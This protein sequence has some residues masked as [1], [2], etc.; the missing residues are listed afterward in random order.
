ML[1]N[2]ILVQNKILKQPRN[3]YNRHFYPIAKPSKT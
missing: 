2:E 3:M 1:L